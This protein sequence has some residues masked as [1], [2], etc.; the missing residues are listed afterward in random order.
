MNKLRYIIRYVNE[1]PGIPAAI[2]FAILLGWFVIGMSRAFTQIHDRTP[3]VIMGLFYVLAV[4]M[5]GSLGF[6]MDR[7]VCKSLGEDDWLYDFLGFDSWV[8]VYRGY[9]DDG[10]TTDGRVLMNRKDA[11][12][13]ASK[14]SGVVAIKKT[15]GLRRRTIN[16]PVS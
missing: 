16:K 1:H 6:S 3:V 9:G 10:A 15:Q 2:V 14:N 5:A 13:W 7:M 8:V 12:Q 4:Y 11:E